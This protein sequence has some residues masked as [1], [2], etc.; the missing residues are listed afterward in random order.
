MV[1][2]RWVGEARCVE[3]GGGG[4]VHSLGGEVVAAHDWEYGDV[5][6]LWAHRCGQKFEVVDGGEW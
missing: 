3:E 6:G 1:P 2:G 4:V 5:A